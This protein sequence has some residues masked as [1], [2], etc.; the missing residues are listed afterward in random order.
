MAHSA[1]VAGDERDDGNGDERNN[2]NV[3]VTTAM[4]STRATAIN[5]ETETQRQRNVQRQCNGD[6]RLVIVT[7]IEIEEEEM[8]RE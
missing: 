8:V 6:A 4:D 5:G 1:T 3:M 7:D 2:S